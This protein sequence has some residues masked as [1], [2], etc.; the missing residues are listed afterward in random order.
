MSYRNGLLLAVGLIALGAAS[1]QAQDDRYR[2]TNDGYGN[3]GYGNDGY[4]DDDRM[5]KTDGYDDD[6]YYED[7][8]YR[9]Q[10]RAGAMNARM[11]GM[12]RNQDG[13]ITR[14]EWRGNAEA[15]SRRDRN[16][17]GVLAGR[18]LRAQRRNANRNRN[19]ND[20]TRMDTLG[21]SD[22]NRDGVLSRGEWTGSREEFDRIDRNRDGYITASEAQYRRY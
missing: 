14:S 13:R 4:R 6:D 3:D 20:D 1:A 21:A 5:Y 2:K 22:R 18:E 7:Q 15:F 10:G 17:D 16:G 11:R 19:R 8:D 9:G 12:D